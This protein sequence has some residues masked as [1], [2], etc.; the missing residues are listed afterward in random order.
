MI[1]ENFEIALILLGKFQNFQKCIAAI[2]P[3]S[4][5]QTCNYSTSATPEIITK[6]IVV[7]NSLISLIRLILEVKYGDDS[8]LAKPEKFCVTIFKGD[9]TNKKET[10]KCIWK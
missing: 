5:S 4:P 10:V 1:F 8:L 2:H 6:L 9:I 3:K 7:S